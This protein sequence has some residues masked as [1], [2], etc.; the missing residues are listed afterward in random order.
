[1]KYGNAQCLWEGLIQQPQFSFCLVLVKLQKKAGP[2]DLRLCITEFPSVPPP[3]C[4]TIASP[5]ES[6]KPK[7]TT[8]EQCV[9]HT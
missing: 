1:M 7:E 8:Y 6:K 9:V 4:G 3:T 2:N 5:K